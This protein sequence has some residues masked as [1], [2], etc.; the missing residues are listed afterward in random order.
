MTPP[1]RLRAL[2]AEPVAGAV[3]TPAQLD[4]DLRAAL[5]TAADTVAKLAAAPDQR[6]DVA[7]I[8]ALLERVRVQLEGEVRSA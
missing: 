8:L 6:G 3:A 4:A 2:G 7:P 1:I 5:R